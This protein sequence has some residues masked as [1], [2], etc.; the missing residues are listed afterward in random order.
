MD[1]GEF[2]VNLHITLLKGILLCSLAQESEHQ[3]QGPPSP[4][5]LSAILPM[6]PIATY[7]H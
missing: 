1:S 2:S 3:H 6:A 5:F 4:A 7:D